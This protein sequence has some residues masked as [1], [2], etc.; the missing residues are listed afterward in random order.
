MD[1]LKQVNLQ[2]LDEQEEKQGSYEKLTPGV[3]LGV[4]RNAFLDKTQNGT[5]YVNFIIDIGEIPNDIE[6]RLVGWAVERMVKKSD[7]SVKNSN[8]GYFSGLVIL[9]KMAKCLG[10]RVNQ[11]TFEEKAVEVWGEVKK[12]PSVKDVINKKFAFGI[13]D[14]IYYNQNGEEK[15]RYELVDVCCAEDTECIEKLKNRIE[16]KPVFKE[17]N[18]QQREPSTDNIPDF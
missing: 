18:K 16:K 8:G 11:L 10:K 4:V 2:E 1:W 17:E 14:R 9:D 5:A 13:R 6:L 15:T 3:Y 7:G 12:L